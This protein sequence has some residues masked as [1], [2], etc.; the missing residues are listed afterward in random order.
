M[1]GSW[2][3]ADCLP[4]GRIIR[5]SHS[6]LSLRLFALAQ[7]QG[8]MTPRQVAIDEA[9]Q[10]FLFELQVALSKFLWLLSAARL[11]I[12]LHTFLCLLRGQGGGLGLW[13]TTNQHGGKM[14]A[15]LII[16]R[17]ASERCDA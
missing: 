15:G 9:R 14:N 8:T 5:G 3:S 12:L 1:L 16:L 7:A 4:D 2:P 10:G 13:A 11:G 6:S 17:V